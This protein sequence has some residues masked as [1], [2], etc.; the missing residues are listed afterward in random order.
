MPGEGNVV[1]F[2]H[3]PSHGELRPRQ[4][5]EGQNEIVRQHHRDA[6]SE[7]G[8][9]EAMRPRSDPLRN[10]AEDRSAHD[11][12]KPRS[13]ATNPESWQ[14]SKGPQRVPVVH[15]HGKA[16]STPSP[17]KQANTNRSATGKFCERNPLAAQESAKDGIATTE[18]AA[19]ADECRHVGPST[20]SSP[21]PEVGITGR[22]S[23]ERI[24]DLASGP[25]APKAS[26]E[27]GQC[28][29]GKRKMWSS[30]LVRKARP[31]F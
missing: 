6:T 8:L 2:P 5:R 10:D 14:V 22:V 16:F 4:L 27:I 28:S 30:G 19:L 9:I 13:V 21:S 24:K 31:K 23:G 12:S 29:S 18:P 17:M 20:V 15:G 26:S 1:N 7:Q 3:R 25:A 11:F